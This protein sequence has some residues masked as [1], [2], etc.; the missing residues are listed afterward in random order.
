MKALYTLLIAVFGYCLALPVVAQDTDEGIYLNSATGDYTVRFLGFDDTIIEGTFFPHTKINPSIKS[1]FD[2]AG[3]DHTKYQYNVKNGR[4]SKQDIAT[5]I[6]YVSSVSAHGQVNPTGWVGSVA[7][8]IGGIGEIVG[9]SSRT[10]RPGMDE[11]MVM[12]DPRWNEPAIAGIPPGGGPVEFAFRS[13][14]LPG[15][16]VIRNRGSAAITRLPDEGPDPETPVGKAYSEL[17][18]NDFVPRL[19]AIPKISNPAPFD[20]VAVL[21]GIQK[22]VK[23]DLV[24]MELVEPSFVTKLDQGLTSAIEAAKRGNTEALRSELRKLR[25]L[26]KG[27]GE[28]EAD[29]HTAA[30]KD[31]DEDQSPPEDRIRTKDWPHPIAKLAARVLD[32][33]LKYVEKRVKGT[34]D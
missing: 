26:L 7:P 22:H 23:D 11:E 6:I 3:D 25:H 14:D 16:G 10:V 29:S 21:S 24:G 34:L 30:A 15:V 5:I 20:A 12:T 18:Q 8:N 2:T 32:F 17:R 13:R 33:D 1:R 9:W 28:A 19:A 4:T 27:F 31:K